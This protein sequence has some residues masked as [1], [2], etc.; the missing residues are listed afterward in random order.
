[1]A[2]VAIGNNKGGSAKTATTVQLAAALGMR[3]RSVLV[4]DLD[5]QANATRR[6]GLVLDEDQPS[7]SEVIKDGR[8]G[9]AVDAVLACGWDHS[10]GF[11]L[12]VLPARFELEARIS[13]AGNL[14]AVHRLRRALTGV[15]EKY[16]VVLYDLPPSLGHLTQLGLA[17]ADVALCCTEP[18][19]DSIEG[20]VRYRDFIANHGADLGNP[21]LRLA[22]VIVTRV[23]Q[24]VGSHGFHLDG[25]ADVLAPAPI[26]APAI[27]ERAAIKDAA[28]TARPLQSFNDPAARELVAK[29]DELAAQLEEVIR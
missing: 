13:E 3:G 5:P 15:G 10:A 7:I 29:Y 19:Y 16:D 20:A 25:L 6:L 1:M 27:P 17:C 8:E 26:W 9:V 22:G 14:G 4:V 18:E 12:S 11:T 21:G 28:D 24:Q 23:R 2:G